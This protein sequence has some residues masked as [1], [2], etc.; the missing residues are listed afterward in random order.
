M[1]RLTPMSRL[2]RRPCLALPF[3]FLT[4]ADRVRLAAGEDYRYT[5]S[6]SGLETWL[7]D[8]LPLLDGGRT[9]DEALQALPDDRRAAARELTAQ[10]YGE[11]VLIDGPAL[12]AH[13]PYPY[14][15]VPEGT[16]R[17]REGL[18][19]PQRDDGVP[20]RVL[21]VLCQDRL[22]YDEVLR[23]NRRCLEGDAPWL[24]A[25]CGPMARGYVSPVF[26]PDAGPC[27]ECLLRWFRRLS[28]APELY[29]DLIDHARQGRPILPAPFPVTAAIVLRQLVLWK[30]EALAAHD[31]PAALYRLHVLETATME[32]T[33]HRVF[34]DP[35]CPTCRRRR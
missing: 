11:R 29:A 1:E 16:G 28:P 14:R 24:W 9:L 8:W 21:T 12:A 7:P 22:D 5:L 32:T 35:E 30:A 6:G 10:L 26:L 15:L 20:T 3:T 4:G 19:S 27:L 13:S 2:P 18:P 25:T 31:P 23:F 33:A 17:L 34:A